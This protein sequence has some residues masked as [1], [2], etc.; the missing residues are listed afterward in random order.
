MALIIP[1]WPEI[2][3]PAGM[4]CIWILIL[5]TGARLNRGPNSTNWF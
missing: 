3:V 1:G 2:L 4:A 5:C